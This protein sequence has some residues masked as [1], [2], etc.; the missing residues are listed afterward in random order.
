VR[1]DNLARHLAG[2][3]IRMRYWWDVGQSSAGRRVDGWMDRE[4]DPIVGWRLVHSCA[5]A[6][7]ADPDRLTGTRFQD[8]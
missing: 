4:S 2:L 1:G 3:L 7:F 5:R 8:R 6:R